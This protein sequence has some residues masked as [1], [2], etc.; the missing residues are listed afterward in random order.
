MRRGENAALPAGFLALPPEARAEILYRVAYKGYLER[1]LR[2]IEKMSGWEN[3]RIPS[4]LDY[5]RA[6][7]LRLEARQ[8]LEKFAPSTIGQASRISG[9]SPADIGVLLVHVKSFGG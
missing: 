4:G 2:Q 7:G 8:K 6:V 9:V 5:S 3:I 1:D